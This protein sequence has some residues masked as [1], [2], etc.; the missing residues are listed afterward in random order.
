MGKG[1]VG[2]RSEEKGFA[3]NGYAILRSARQGRSARVRPAG[4]GIQPIVLGNRGSEVSSRGRKIGPL[5]GSYSPAGTHTPRHIHEFG[6][7]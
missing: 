6:S 2:V 4:E 1:E 5:K 7:R 3:D